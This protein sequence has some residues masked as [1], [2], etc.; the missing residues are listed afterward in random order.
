MISLSTPE[1]LSA[2]DKL[3][4]PL[5]G[6]FEGKPGVC[7]FSWVPPNNK[8]TRFVI[9]STI[10]PL[11]PVVDGQ[12]IW[13]SAAHHHHQESFGSILFP[14]VSFHVASDKF[15]LVK[16]PL[17]PIQ[18]QQQPPINCPKTNTP[19]EGQDEWPDFVLLK[20]DLAP[21]MNPN[22]FWIP[23]PILLS[24]GTPV[25]VFGKIE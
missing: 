3:F 7:G 6:H 9:P 19:M 15:P 17:S 4:E 2:E 18:Q 12:C 13:A 20:S 5:K 1:V 23:D 24:P 21:H 11:T 14:S 8:V 10:F 25:A 22:H 16:I